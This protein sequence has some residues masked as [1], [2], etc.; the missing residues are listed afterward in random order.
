VQRAWSQRRFGGDKMLLWRD[1]DPDHP[2][3]V[4]SLRRLSYSLLFRILF[5]TLVYYTEW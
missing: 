3:R 4:P 1:S 2:F 5:F